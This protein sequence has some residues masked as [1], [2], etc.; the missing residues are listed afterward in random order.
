M[1]NWCL[2]NPLEGQKLDLDDDQMIALEAYA[3]Y[4]RRGVPLAPGKH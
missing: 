4:E 2:M 1:I 3:T